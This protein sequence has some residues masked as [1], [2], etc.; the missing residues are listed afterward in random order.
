MSQRF[1]FH[2]QL[3]LKHFPL[4]WLIQSGVCSAAEVALCASCAAGAQSRA[5]HTSSAPKHKPLLV[6]AQDPT[7]PPAVWRPPGGSRTYT[8]V[9]E[10][11]LHLLR[12]SHPAEHPTVTGVS[13]RCKTRTFFWNSVYFSTWLII[14][15]SWQHHSLQSPVLGEIQG[16]RIDLSVFNSTGTNHSKNTYFAKPEWIPQQ[17]TI[18]QYSQQIRTLKWYLFFFLKSLVQERLAGTCGCTHQCWELLCWETS[19]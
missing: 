6:T 16:K 3:F 5:R 8:T 7:A 1:Q 10:K 13:T 2:T 12:K 15:Y 17:L 19:S 4:Q 11:T 9:C 14:S 18:L